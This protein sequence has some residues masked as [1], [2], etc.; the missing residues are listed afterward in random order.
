MSRETKSW[1]WWLDEEATTTES[2]STAAVKSAA[3]AAFAAESRDAEPTAAFAASSEA[4]M[5]EAEPRTAFAAGSQKKGIIRELVAGH[6]IPPTTEVSWKAQGPDAQQGKPMPK[7]V[8]TAA[9]WGAS[10]TL[11]GPKRVEKATAEL[12]RQPCHIQLILELLDPS[13][14]EAMAQQGFSSYQSTDNGPAILWL[15]SNWDV[16]I[17]TDRNFLGRNDRYA[18]QAVMVQLEP[19]REGFPPIRIASCHLHNEAAKKKEESEAVATAY[20]EWMRT[21]EI[22]ICFVD[23]NQFSHPRFDGISMLAKK[24]TEENY[25]QPAANPPLWG[26]SQQSI[27]EGG[28]CCGFIIANATLTK[29]S[30][31]SHGTFDCPPQWRSFF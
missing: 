9:N 3:G 29:G 19:K 20:E 25:L 5:T 11:K 22:D 26:R 2:S 24:F 1:Q 10:R 31:H 12:L 14:A 28:A 16:D 17:A 15:A 30:I 21:R 13:I 7:I 18:G 27:D 4:T 8:I 23:G 6:R